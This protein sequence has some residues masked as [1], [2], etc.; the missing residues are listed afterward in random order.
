MLNCRQ[1]SSFFEIWGFIEFIERSDRDEACFNGPYWNFTGL[2]RVLPN[3]HDFYRILPNVHG[4]YRAS[5]SLNICVFFLLY[6]RWLNMTL[7][8]VPFAIKLTLSENEKKNCQYVDDWFNEYYRMFTEFTVFLFCCI[9]DDS[10]EYGAYNSSFCRISNTIRSIQRNPRGMVLR[11][12]PNIHGFYRVFFIMLWSNEYY[13]IFTDFTE[14]VFC[15]ILDDS[16]EYKHYQ[17]Y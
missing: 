3:F 9:L 15:C 1:L 8:T 6:V 7:M 10:S 12:L 2:Y 4:F 5:Y 17:K 11:V 13:R 14:F 16:S